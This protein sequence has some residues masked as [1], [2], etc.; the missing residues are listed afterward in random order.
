MLCSMR[1]SYVLFSLIA[2]CTAGLIAQNADL[3]QYQTWM[4]AG[5]GANGA[6]RAAVAAK[7]A[8]AIKENSAKA[9]EAFDSIAKYW[10]TKQKEDA[11]KFA[12][13]A[14]DAAKAVGAASDEAAQQAALG[15]IAGACNSCHPIYRNGKDFKQ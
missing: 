4:K 10:G 12:E 6:L 15:K 9:A 8:A 14:R 11:V 5:A 1:R 13:E 2:F 7:D 3:A